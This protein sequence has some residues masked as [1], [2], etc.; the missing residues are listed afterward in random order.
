VSSRECSELGLP[1]VKGITK[2]KALLNVMHMPEIRVMPRENKRRGTQNY[3]IPPG[4]K[5]E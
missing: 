1:S 4:K 3:E 5:T 2:R